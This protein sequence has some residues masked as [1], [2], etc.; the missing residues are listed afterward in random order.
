MM[1]L[2]EERARTYWVLSLFALDLWIIF[3][4]IRDITGSLIAAKIVTG[5]AFG[6]GVLSAVVWLIAKFGI[7]AIFGIGWALCSTAVIA[8]ALWLLTVVADKLGDQPILLGPSIFG[9]I[10]I[11]F[12]VLGMM[13]RAVY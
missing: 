5:A 10:A 11:S 12:I 9:I 2:A 4:L 7:L 13:R 8:V 3:F 1:S 6:L